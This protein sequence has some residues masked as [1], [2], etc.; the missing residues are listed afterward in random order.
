VSVSNVAGSV[1]IE[2]TSGDHVMVEA[3]VVGDENSPWIVEAHADGNEVKVRARQMPF[4]SRSRRDQ[5]QG[6]GEIE[7]AAE[8]SL[9]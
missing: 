6:S 4:E 7:A 2:G 3:K 5:P 9:L 8:N 1:S